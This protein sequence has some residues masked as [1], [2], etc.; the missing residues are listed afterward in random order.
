MVQFNKEE[1][2]MEEIKSI[3]RYL[4]ENGNDVTNKKLQKLL[5]FSQAWFITLNTYEEDQDQNL[6]RLFREK[7]QAWRHGPV[8]P[9]SYQRYKKYSYFSI[10][11]KEVEEFDVLT[12]EE[13]KKF[14][15]QIL[16]TYDDFTGDELESIS[17]QESPWKDA[18]VANENR[19]IEPQAMFSY[20][21]E[22]SVS[23]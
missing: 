9:E 23:E 15:N 2:N 17:H 20:F 10:E 8:I 6:T 19:E 22:I 5:Y 1:N 16:E 21:R 11:K 7:I 14:L 18:F 12:N 4:I 3:E 13:V